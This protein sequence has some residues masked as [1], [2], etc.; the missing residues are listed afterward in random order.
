MSSCF[1]ILFLVRN[2]IMSLKEPQT[3]LD[4]LHMELYNGI[5]NQIDKIK[6]SGLYYITRDKN[7]TIEKT[8]SLLEKHFDLITKTKIP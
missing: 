1:F 2:M 3:S 7:S 6:D 4:N 5:K 8:L